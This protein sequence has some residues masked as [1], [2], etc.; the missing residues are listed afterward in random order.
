MQ[1]T[2]NDMDGLFRD[3]GA[4][5][6]LKTGGGD[7]D[8]VFSRLQSGE[9]DADI[10]GVL[11]PL[12]PK[13]RKR[14]L[15]IWPLLLVLLIYPGY[16][17]MKPNNAGDAAT[18]NNTTK[19]EQQPVNRQAGQNKQTANQPE[20]GT[21]TTG[22]TAESGAATKS[23]GNNN[24]PVDEK[25]VTGQRSNNNADHTG[26]V[27]VTSGSTAKTTT[28]RNSRNKN[29]GGV[30]NAA[31]NNARNGAGVTENNNYNTAVTSNIHSS[32]TPQAAGNT[33]N[34]ERS[35][36]YLHPLDASIV[37]NP[38]SLQNSSDAD[39]MFENA[40]RT[41][42]KDSAAPMIHLRGKPGYR[43]GVYI[44]MQVAG[45]ISTVKFEKGSVGYSAG[46]LAGYRFS[47]RLSA[48]A[49]VMYSHKAYY[50]SGEYFKTDKINLPEHVTIINVDGYCNMIEVPV[51]V[52]YYF[53][54]HEKS[55]WYA[56]AG[57]TSY[58][59]NKEKYTSLYKRYNNEYTA[60]WQRKNASKNI[61]SIMQLGAGYEHAAG[62]LGTLRVEPYLKV[63]LKGVGIGSLPLTSMGLNIGIT[64][65]LGRK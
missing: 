29:T 36:I 55:S 56:A 38:L 16:R 60:D 31:G 11:P 52:H 10:P 59:M 15:W 57:L 43:K 51:N 26:A 27:T 42:L 24:N 44:G 40:H 62:V 1:P 37:L 23:A 41:P 34:E 17:L 30:K 50:S 61:F 20:P 45:D 58:F 4:N 2:S 54:V 6:P 7:F 49:G 25:S 53:S 13:K 18:V 8:A 22:V 14:Y 28:L 48:E 3:A 33:T 65:S 64:K 12:S 35:N 39:K 46:I 32:F 19:T 5:Y 63:S 9:G 47:K 21:T